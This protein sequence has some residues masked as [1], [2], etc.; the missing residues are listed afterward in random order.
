MNNKARNLL[1]LCLTLFIPNCFSFSVRPLVICPKQ[2]GTALF[3][4][5]KDSAEPVFVEPGKEGD[6]F[7][8]E[9]VEE[10]EAGQPSE[11]TIMKEVS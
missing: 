6:V 7:T 1:I 4:D 5:N 3:E 9:E 8:Q 10:I 2:S 11:M